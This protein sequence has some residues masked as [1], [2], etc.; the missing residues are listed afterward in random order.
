MGFKHQP[1]LSFTA[2]LLWQASAADSEYVFVTNAQMDPAYDKGWLWTGEPGTPAPRD[3]KFTYG[4]NCYHS[5]SGFYY[6]VIAWHR[7]NFPYRNAGRLD[8]SRNGYLGLYPLSPHWLNAL[9]SFGDFSRQLQDYLVPP[10]WSLKGLNPTTL[11]V[12][13]VEWNIKIVDLPGREVNLLTEKDKYHLN[14]QS[15]RAA[16]FGLRILSIGSK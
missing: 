10:L 8:S 2:E 14:V 16:Q 11:R 5:D 13:D 12:G 4:F 9:T 1:E 15:G 7:N 3:S 6:E